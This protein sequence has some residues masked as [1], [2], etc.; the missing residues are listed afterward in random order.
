MLAGVAA[1]GV[2][3]AVSASAPA[4]AMDVTSAAALTP[5]RR[6]RA[7]VEIVIFLKFPFRH[8]GA[9]SR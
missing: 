4:G 9:S 8:D 7:P 6:I 2:A 3:G 5:K 1:A